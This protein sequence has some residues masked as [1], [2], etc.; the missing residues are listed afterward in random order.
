MCR[1][2]N[3]NPDATCFW[4]Y[5]SHPHLGVINDTDRFV[6]FHNKT[7]GECT[8]TFEPSQDNLGKWSCFFRLR[9][10]VTQ[11]DVLSAQMFLVG[12][13]PAGKLN[14]LVGVLASAVLVLLLILFGISFYNEHNRTLRRLELRN[15]RLQSQSEGYD[16]ERYTRTPTKINFQFQDAHSQTVSL[17]EGCPAL[18][19]PNQNIYERVSGYSSPAS[20]MSIYENMH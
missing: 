10:A 14:W 7:S 15:R 5:S 9:S 11:A 17:P 13:E 1:M 2:R 16:R 6:V 20:S 4:R 19:S 12:N 3:P 8:L 18:P